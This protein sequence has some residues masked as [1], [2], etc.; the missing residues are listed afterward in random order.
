MRVHAKAAARVAETEYAA[1]Q[2]ITRQNAEIDAA[3]MR[4]EGRNRRFSELL[5]TAYEAQNDGEL[6][7]LMDRLERALRACA[8]YR[9]DL[10]DRAGALALTEVTW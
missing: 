9:A 3:L 7:R 1:R 6:E 2:I 4:I 10:A 5:E 8:R